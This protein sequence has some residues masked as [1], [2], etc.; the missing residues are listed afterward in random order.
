MKVFLLA[1]VLSQSILASPHK[2]APTSQDA[3]D[4]SIGWSA[5]PTQPPN[6]ELV[7]RKLFENAGIARR[8]AVTSGQLIGYIGQ[9]NTCGYI[10]GQL[11]MFKES[12]NL[13][14]PWSY[15]LCEQVR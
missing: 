13:V 8:E 14:R 15:T 12:A 7:K 1:A 2:P 9:D 10:D 5:R 3:V 4:G 6:L 11:G